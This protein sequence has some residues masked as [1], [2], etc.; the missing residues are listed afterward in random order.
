MSKINTRINLRNDTL[1]RWLVS[2]A[3]LNKGEVALARM[4]GQLS[5]RYEMRIGVGDKTWSE[6]SSGGL[7][8]PI[9]NVTGLESALASKQ[10]TIKF[11]SSAQWKADPSFVPAEG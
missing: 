1:L 6:L 10:D 7:Q 5:D 8:V 3:K 11:A 9:K 4:S 2:N